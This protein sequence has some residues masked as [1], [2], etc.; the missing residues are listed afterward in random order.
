M[1]HTPDQECVKRWME[2]SERILGRFKTGGRVG[3]S[4]RGAPVG[5]QPASAPSVC[6]ASTEWGCSE[7]A[8]AR[9][10]VLKRPSAPAPPAAGRG[11]R[12]G[13]RHLRVE[14]RGDLVPAIDEMPACDLVG[15]A[16]QSRLQL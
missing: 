4:E 15:R 6:R 10:L 5:A 2:G 11:A 8:P 3:G 12:C 9:L 16:W 1:M 7:P 13:T 14:D